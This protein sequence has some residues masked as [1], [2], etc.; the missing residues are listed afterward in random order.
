[1]GPTLWNSDPDIFGESNPDAIEY[2]T[3]LY[4]MP[5][6][7]GSHI[8]MLHETPLCMGIAWENENIYWVFDGSTGS[9]DRVD[10]K[11]DHGMGWDDHSDGI[12]GEFAKGEF[13]RV[14]DVPSHLAFDPTTA[15]LYIADTGNSAI[16]VL[17][18]TSGTRGSDLPRMEPGTQHYEMDDALVWTLIDG[19][20]HGM[21]QP[22]GLALFEDTLLVTDH[23]TGKIFAFDLEGELVDWIDTDRGSDSLMGIV[24][25][26]LDDIWFVDARTEQVIRFQP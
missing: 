19:A 23:A 15:Y 7:L 12:I 10:F 5:V 24:A 11:D 21:E 25:R 14:E 13:S 22:S 18:T 3:D 26:S 8:D 16:K 1:M 20:D 2:L 6:D 9:I 4:G 17:D